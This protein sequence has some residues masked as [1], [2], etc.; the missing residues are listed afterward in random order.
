MAFAARVHRSRGQATAVAPPRLAGR[1]AAR[2][3]ALAALALGFEWARALAVRQPEIALPA[4]LVGGAALG[5]LGLGFTFGE[6]G[7]SRSRLGFRLLAGLLLGA[8]L[9][10]PAAARRGPVP[11]LPPPLALAAISVSIGEEIAFRGALFAAIARWLGPAP[12]IAGSSLVFAAGHLLSHP[13]E[14]LLAV[15]LAGLLLAAWR[16]AC[17]DLVAPIVAHCVADLAL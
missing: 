13:P 1:P 16:W 12:A 15:T 14:F 4:L 8:V 10:L 2:A 9:L 5:A 11:L 6:L 3:V 7:L 17:G